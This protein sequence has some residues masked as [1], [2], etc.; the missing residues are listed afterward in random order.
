MKILT[1]ILIISIVLN[2][3][4]FNKNSKEI[5]I[6]NSICNLKSSTVLFSI[7][8]EKSDMV[9]KILNADIIQ[10]V[11]DYD[12]TLF[13]NNYLLSTICIDWKKTLK[14]SVEDYLKNKE[15]PKDTSY[16]KKVEKNYDILSNICQIKS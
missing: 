7:N 3:Y 8:S 11:H 9:K 13:S 6:A 15:S 1:F 5:Q 14:Q 2:I 10:L 16:F 12:K 4:L